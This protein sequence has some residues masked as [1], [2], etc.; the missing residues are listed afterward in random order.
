MAAA[1]KVNMD[2]EHHLTAPAIHVDDY[3]ITGL[4]N[5]T[6]L[7]D[8]PG[9]RQETGEE[10]VIVGNIVESGVMGLRHNEYVDRRRGARVLERDHQVVLIDF[11][12]GQDT[13]DYLAEDTFHAEIPIV[14]VVLRGTAAALHR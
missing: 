3:A 1:H 7:S 8:P 12:G 10:R 4:G 14:S 5:A 2:M 13:L 9:H 6:L 11:V